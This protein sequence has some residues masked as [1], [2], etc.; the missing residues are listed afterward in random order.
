M[1]TVPFFRGTSY[2]R[3][4]FLRAAPK[5]FLVGTRRKDNMAPG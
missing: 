1:V 5:N 2:T 4:T 3:A